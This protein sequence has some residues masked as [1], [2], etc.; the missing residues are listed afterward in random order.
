MKTNLLIRIILVQVL[1]LNQVRA[2]DMKKPETMTDRLPD[3]L[4][5]RRAD[6]YK[7]Q[8]EQYLRHWILDGYNSRSAETWSRDYSSIG[9]F[10]RSVEPNR[11]RW[12]AILNPPE[13]RKTGP[14]IKEPHQ[15]LKDLNAEWIQLPLGP[16]TAEA[17]LV[18]PKNASK[19]HPVPLIIAQHGIGS[20]PESTFFL[21]DDAYH[22][23][24]RELLKA[25]FAVLAPM[26]LQSYTRRNYIERL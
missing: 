17:I 21:D 9:A 22:S 7:D 13:L 23:Y 3:S 19:D 2:Q 5:V 18:F 14:L 11:E 16:I 20:I 1:F 4:I 25:G 8:L 6:E 12:K 26:N 24:A 10:T 15:Y